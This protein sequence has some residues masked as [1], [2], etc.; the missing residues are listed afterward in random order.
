MPISIFLVDDHHVFQDGIAALISFEEDLEVIGK[1]SSVEEFTREI[2]KYSPDLILMDI[3]LGDGTGINAAK[4]WKEKCP[5]CKILMLSMHREEKYVRDVVNAGADGFLTKDS[6]TQEM[7]TAIRTVAGGNPF[8]SQGVFSHIVN[9]MQRKS[10]D[11]RDKNGEDLTKRE[12][13]VIK[14]IADEL[15]NQEIADK[16]FISIRT[17]DTHRQNLL[18]K[19]GAKNT[20]GLVKYALRHKLV[21]L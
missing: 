13:E 20:A 9:L 12:C 4:W 5:E 11:R 2:P 10:S 6:G 16:L 19:T 3:S 17:V 7:L 21:T 1:A 14:L 18:M 8:Y 15:S